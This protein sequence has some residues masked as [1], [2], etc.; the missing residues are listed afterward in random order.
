M[1]GSLSHRPYI[2]LAKIARKRGKKVFSTPNYR[3][4]RC[5][6]TSSKKYIKKLEDILDENIEIASISGRFYT[7]G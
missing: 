2:G 5:N 3:W 7:Y 1:W 6:P 4:K